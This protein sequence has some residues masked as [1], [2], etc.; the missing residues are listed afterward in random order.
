[1]RHFRDGMAYARAR[2]PLVVAVVVVIMVSFL[3]IAVSQLVEPIARHVFDVGAGIYGLLIA[4][5]GAG[6]VLG[7]LFTVWFGDHFL[8]SRVAA[9]GIA[10][11][12]AG[13]LVLGLAPGW[14]LGLGALF[15]MGVAQVLSMV[16]SN[17]A[18]QLNVDERYRGRV[19]A[20]FTMCFFAAAPLGALVGGVLGEW[21]GLRIVVVTASALLATWFV[22][23]FVR[24]RALSPLD[25]SMPVYDEDG[26]LVPGTDFDA[27]AHLV[28]EPVEVNRPDRTPGSAGRRR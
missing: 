13:L 10:M 11:M 3:G 14:E 18:L 7:S 24:Y 12:V 25:A 27:G 5:Y 22:W 15:F 28:I 23:V 2:L 17:T 19:S 21:I 16:S 6:A 8:R 4:C 1:M 9:V 26:V 20:L